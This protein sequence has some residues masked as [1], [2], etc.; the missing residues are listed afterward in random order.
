[1][2]KKLLLNPNFK[3]MKTYKSLILASL[4]LAGAA[5][6][7]SC[8]KEGEIN[9]EIL[10]TVQ[11]EA[12]ATALFDDIFAQIEKGESNAFTT[13]SGE[14]ETTT[15]CP[16]VTIDPVGPNFPKT[17]TIDFG[18][19]GC[20][21]E[22][23]NV[24]TGKII[25]IITGRHWVEGSVKSVSFEDFT[26]NGFLVEG[27]KTITNMGRKENQNMYWKIEVEGAKITSPQ[28]VAFQWE[29]TREREWVAGEDTPA[30]IWDDIFEITGTTTGIN[31]FQKSF[32]VTVQD[33]LVAKLACRFIVQ[34]N[35]LIQLEGY[36]D[37]ILDYGDGECDSV[38]T[39][40]VN[41]ETKTI[42]L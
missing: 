7:Q 27:T 28:G 13:K 22:N 16:V 42:R 36:P 12:V 10:E 30:Y 39:V 31:R 35:V 18:D 17:I 20:E 29:S 34:G 6:F 9:E 25:F 5:F 26:V 32:A 21:G 40:T 38:A 14:V 11:E 19:I 1:M 15:S 3:T 4:F 24:R 8:E 23:G 37:A 41:G 33:P 2:P